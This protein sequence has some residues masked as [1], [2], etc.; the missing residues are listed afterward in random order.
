MNNV[1]WIYIIGS[2]SDYSRCKIGKTINNPLKRYLNLR[3]AD[4]K[5]HL[6]VAYC[7]PHKLLSKAEAAIHLE[8]EEFRQLTHED[9]LSEW[10]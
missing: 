2:S 8:L 1:G 5:L 4:P 10:F 7:V 6:Q 9:T 3:T